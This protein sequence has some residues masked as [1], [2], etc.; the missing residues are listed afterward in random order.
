MHDATGSDPTS[1]IVEL[2]DR[3][4]RKARFVSEIASQLARA[5]VSLDV[6]EPALEA[7]ETA[8][9]ALVREQYCGDPHLV[10]TDL[11]IVALV[12]SRLEHNGDQADPLS[13]ATADIEA[14]W[15]RWLGDYLATH[16]CG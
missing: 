11:R 1:A 7:L 12:N 4:P 14:I 13:R 10:G 3:S 16:R 8:G 5:N 15:Q 6:L 9:R 2:L